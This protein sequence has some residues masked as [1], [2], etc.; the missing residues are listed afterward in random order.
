MKFKNKTLLFLSSLAVA[1]VPMASA[2]EETKEQQAARLK[3]ERELKQQN[4]KKFNELA[5]EFYMS[6]Q[7][8][9]KR[10]M[11]VM[12]QILALAGQPGVDIQRIYGFH[13]NLARSE[14]ADELR[15][16]LKGFYEKMLTRTTGDLKVQNLQDYADFLK[17]HKLADQAKID[18]VLA[19]R[20]KVKDISFRKLAEIYAAELEL[21]KADAAGEKWLAA[22]KDDREKINTA[23]HLARNVFSRYKVYGSKF[24]DKYAKIWMSLLKDNPSAMISAINWYGPYAQTYALISDAEYEKIMASRY[25]LPGAT[26]ADLCTA[27]VHDIEREASLQEADNLWK[28]A[29][30]AAKTAAERFR[31]YQAI[32][33]VRVHG[34]N[35]DPL[36][37]HRAALWERVLTGDK[38]L[39]DSERWAGTLKQILDNYIYHSNLNYTDANKFLN[40]LAADIRKLIAPADVAATAAEADLKKF[41]SESKNMKDRQQAQNTIT[42]M[43][44][45]MR[46]ARTKAENVR[47]AAIT[48]YTAL[49]NLNQKYAARYYAAP[50]PM[51]LKRAIAAREQIIALI[52]ENRDGEKLTQKREMAKLALDAKDYALVK[53][54]AKEVLSTPVNP[55]NPKTYETEKI[56]VTYYLGFT[57]YD[58][59]NYKDAV[60]YLQP[61][62]YRNDYH[63]NERL[64]D[65][66]VRSYV[67]LGQY[68]DAVKY[69]DNM[70]KYAK[71]YLRS[72]LQ[73]QVKELKERAEETAE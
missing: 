10:A 7:I 2:A 27:Y 72:R 9:A 34:R 53:K 58:E 37:K 60:E 35:I 69:T 24:A 67:A 68:K 62:T 14:K 20:Y 23:S 38:E 11:T 51:E 30:A 39:Y 46:D 66:L 54:L 15:L 6:F 12:D 19:E 50:S 36:K 32:C 52:P 56:Y 17:K 71:H 41:E 61:M 55:K 22:A 33:R 21:E 16:Y 1:V 47:T 65:N 4:S 26:S 31:I 29:F 42:D 44:N 40:A 18:A 5:G 57:A 63:F 73:E 48:V 45:K 59:E 13:S 25:S 28:K 3:A 8:D 43:R 70:I 49:A 64:Y